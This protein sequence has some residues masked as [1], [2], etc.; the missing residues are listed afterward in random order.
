LAVLRIDLIAGRILSVAR[1]TF[2]SRREEYAPDH[3]QSGINE[4][5]PDDEV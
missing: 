1:F 5:S 2:D 4:E 3:R